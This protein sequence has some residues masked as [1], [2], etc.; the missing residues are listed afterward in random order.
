MRIPK[1]CQCCSPG[2]PLFAKKTTQTN[3]GGFVNLTPDLAFRDNSSCQNNPKQE[4]SKLTYISNFK[5]TLKGVYHMR[6]VV[7][8]F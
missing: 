8:F 2:I 7:E 4:R 6:N 3:Q 5:I 1:P